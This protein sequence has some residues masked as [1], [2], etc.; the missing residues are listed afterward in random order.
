MKRIVTKLAL[1]F[2]GM[3]ALAVALVWLVQA[4]LLSDSYLNQRVATIDEAVQSTV[5]APQ[6]DYAALE[7]ALNVSLL[8]LNAEGSV[9]YQSDGLPMR[10]QIVRRVSE[11]AQTAGGGVEYLQTE[12]EEARYAL[13]SRAVAG[14]TLI[15]VF[16]LV[17]VTEASRVLLQQLWVITA[18]LMGAALILSLVLSRLFSRPVVSVTQAAKA[19]AAGDYSV[20]TP[21]R[22]RDEIGQLTQALNELGDELGKAEE[23]RRELIANV[24][25]E[26]RAPLTIIR[27]YAETLRDV[28]WPNEEKRTAQLNAICDESVRLGALVSDILD[29]SRLQSGAD[30]LELT[31][32]PLSDALGEIIRGFEL[33]AGRRDIALELSCDEGEVRFDRAQMVQVV[34]N[35]LDNA[36]HHARERSRIRI[37]GEKR[38]AC[39]RV[40][41]ENV[42]DPIPPDELPNI[43]DRYHRAPRVG[44]AGGLGTGLG[45]AIVK[46]ILTR[47][48][49]NFGVESDEKKTVF[50]FETVSQ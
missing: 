16:S 32:F 49:V 48:G 2:L 36:V 45:L 22:S 21:V 11:L 40:S 13:V 28:T 39:M 7:S 26:L 25:H 3:A 5:I 34:S 14:G 8:A 31:D 23:L 30:K 4:V 19:L 44:E 37:R 41:I 35:L 10:G 20:K 33:A 1:A 12:T 29:Y 6:T 38:G 24:S 42:G 9:V 43:W 46:S 15:V 27:G 17:D 50:W 18:V 47:H